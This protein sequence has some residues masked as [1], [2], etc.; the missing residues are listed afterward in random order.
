MDLS[1]PRK[2]AKVAA[3]GKCSRKK[4]QKE[5]GQRSWRK[6]SRST[7]RS[8]NRPKDVP[9][10][11]FATMIAIGSARE[12]RFDVVS[13]AGRTGRRSDRKKDRRGQLRARRMTVT[14]Q[15]GIKER[16]YFFVS[17]QKRSR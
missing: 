3:D 4:L 5:T 1:A 8:E 14:C 13:L 11:L 6:S 16:F 12:T 10:V 7:R 15:Y 2:R 17:V 9:R